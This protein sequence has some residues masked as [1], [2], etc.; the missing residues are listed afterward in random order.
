MVAKTPSITV[1]S[2]ISVLTHLVI[3]QI[4]GV[5]RAGTIS[6]DTAL[7]ILKSLCAHSERAVE[8]S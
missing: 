1:V 4:Q 3:C 7:P 5:M 8:S 6:C 2:P